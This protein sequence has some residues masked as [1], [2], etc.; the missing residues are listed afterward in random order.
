M[1]KTVYKFTNT[2]GG[3]GTKYSL[4]VAN[5]AYL[6]NDIACTSQWSM[7]FALN[8]QFSGYGYADTL[9]N[10]TLTALWPVRPFFATNQNHT[11]IEPGAVFYQDKTSSNVIFTAPS[12]PITIYSRTA[13]TS[14][15]GTVT[16]SGAQ[17]AETGDFVA[18][19]V[20]SANYAFVEWRKGG[21]QYS[22]DNP[23]TI[24]RSSPA[25]DVALTA[26]FRYLKHTLSVTGGTGGSPTSTPTP[27]SILEGTTVTLNPRPNAGYAFS[28]WTITGGITETS[29]NPNY[30]FS[31][32]DSNVSAVATYSQTAFTL[33]LVSVAGGTSGTNPSN[34]SQ[35]ETG[36]S[37]TATAFPDFGHSFSDWTFSGASSGTSS[38]NPV[39]FDM[40]SGNTTLTPAFTAFDRHA[41]TLH[42]AGTTS[43][44]G[45]LAGLTYTVYVD[46][47]QASTTMSYAVD[48][49][50]TEVYEG[51]VCSV[52]GIVT[53]GNLLYLEGIYTDA[54]CTALYAARP[55]GQTQWSVEISPTDDVELWFNFVQ[56]TQKTVE[57]HASNADTYTPSNAAETAG[58]AVSASPSVASGGTV[59]VG[60]PV[61]FT[62]SAPAQ[63]EVKKWVAYYGD[64]TSEEFAASV[65][66]T[67]DMDQDTEIVCVFGV[68]TYTV[69]IENDG[70]SEDAGAG[71]V[72][73]QKYVGGNYVNQTNPYE[74]VFGETLKAVAT[75]ETGFAFE[76]WYRD[77]VKILGAGT[78]YLFTV[79]Q[80]VTLTAKYTANISL[81]GSVDGVGAVYFCNAD[82]TVDIAPAPYTL[83]VIVGDP[84]YLRHVI[85]APGN[86]FRGYYDDGAIQL[87]T[88]QPGP[89]VTGI[90]EGFLD[91]VADFDSESDYVYLRMTND[92]D[93]VEN[94][95]LGALAATGAIE[96]LTESE[97]EAV[98]GATPGTYSASEQGRNRYYK[99]NRGDVASVSAIALTISAFKG[100]MARD[101]DPDQT[102]IVLG[103]E[104]DL[105]SD[106]PASL[107]MFR[108]LSVR[109]VWR[110]GSYIPL[111]AF[112]ATG[113]DSTMG[114]MTMSPKGEVESVTP[115]GTVGQY[116][117]DDVVVVEAVPKNTFKFVGWYLD[118][119]TTQLF[120][121]NRSFSVTVW[122]T[123]EEE[124][125]YAKFAQDDNA[126][127]LWEGGTAPKNAVWRSKRMEASAPFDPTCVRVQ[128][129]GYPVTVNIYACSSPNTPSP[130]VPTKRVYAMSES[131]V[132]LPSGRKE[133]YF[134]VEVE[135]PYPVNDVV[136]SSSLG[137]LSQ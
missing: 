80:D 68:S 129:D 75:A 124:V 120:T 40:P 26:V 66:L 59:A 116:L 30:S 47:P 51:F 64:S 117:E 89:I 61:T 1:P 125:Y 9:R 137:G 20:P 104:S 27:G 84:Y 78:E 90:C 6:F 127:Y 130:S 35:I 11:A 22:E 37:V 54:G 52:G 93:G 128:A 79:N 10:N 50:A 46:L 86:F 36:T 119:A 39:V 18:T 24:A 135:S 38:D 41:I 105:P 83:A 14:T 4:S 85:L 131:P 134:E 16:T 32:P 101:M 95:G 123:A 3:Y 29:Y 57:Y 63:W 74:A 108:N 65:T 97:F 67:V 87:F 45:A 111:S 110:Y 82:G 114:Y 126:V 98:F 33:T 8:Q 73:L 76:G 2:V 17:Y 55:S 44:S 113:S 94:T 103:P 96:E 132:R 13:V 62:A 136:M 71:T 118:A 48:T 100:W 69:L 5:N 77:G 133:R 72:V 42:R 107:L 70:P 15:G 31:M 34:A 49:L 115:A 91:I 23:V 7:F 19:A 60:T 43:Y 92:P 81:V 121:T 106:N 21:V 25:E 122:E 112:Y 58:C 99:F 56:I 102:E 28:H 12:G 53:N 88:D 109:A